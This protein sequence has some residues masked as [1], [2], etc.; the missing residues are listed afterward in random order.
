MLESHV[1]VMGVLYQKSAVCSMSDSSSR[2]VLGVCST[3][4]RIELGDDSK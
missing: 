1:R 4:Y 2:K 3:D